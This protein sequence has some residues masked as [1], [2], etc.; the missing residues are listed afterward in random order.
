MSLVEEK[1][2]RT[3]IWLFPETYNKID[4]W[5]GKSNCKS[6]SEFI[7]KAVLFYISSLV[8]KEDNYLPYTMTSVLQGMM[9]NTEKRQS[10]L[11]FK[12]AVELDIMSHVLASAVDVDP[13]QLERIRGFCVEEVKRSV[14]SISLA[15]ALQKESEENES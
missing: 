7:E 15:S 1:K 12:L 14:G 6:R 10:K 5:L 2:Q 3:A 11:L 9:D 13:M 8:V 4:T